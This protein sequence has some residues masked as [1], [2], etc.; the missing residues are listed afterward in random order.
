LHDHHIIDSEDFVALIDGNLFS[1][2]VFNLEFGNAAEFFG[3]MR[4]N[5][6]L[7][8]QGDGCNLS[9]PFADRFTQLFKCCSNGAILYRRLLIEGKNIQFGFNIS[10]FKRRSFFFTGD[11]SIP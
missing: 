6:K 4:H 10:I 7:I 11:F 3:V 5:T 2:P 1:C 9:I 8:C